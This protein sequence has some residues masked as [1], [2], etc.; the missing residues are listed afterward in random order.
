MLQRKVTSQLERWKRSSN[1]ALLVY[2]ARQV[3]KTTAIRDFCSSAFHKTAEINFS[4]DAH[5]TSLFLEVK[6]LKDFEATLALLLGYDPQEGDV[7]FFDEIQV[8][9]EARQRAIAANPEFA[10]RSTDLL[11]LA[12]PIAEQGKYRLILS[13]SLLGV[14]V[15]GINLN[16]TG[17]VDEITMYPMDFEEFLWADKVPET[18]ISQAKS[19]FEQ[20]APMGEELNGFFLAEYRKYTVVGGLP[21]AVRRYVETKSLADAS[22]AQQSVLSWYRKDII[23]YAPAGSRLIILEMFQ[24]LP[25]E[26]NAKNKKFVKSHM[27]VPNFK[28]LDLKDRFLWLSSA[29]IALPVY[30][31]D[32]PVSPLRSSV[33]CKTVKLFSNDVGLLV[34]QLFEGELQDSLLLPSSGFDFGA[35]YENAAATQLLCHG[36]L[37]YYHSNK[38]GGEIDFLIE[39]DLQVLP[40]EIKSGK[41]NERGLYEHK[42]LDHY[43]ES[44]PGKIGYV[45]GNTNVF[46]ERPNIRNYPIYM[47]EFLSKSK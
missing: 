14:T 26:V 28:N 38:K 33:N 32:N 45:F 25:S 31:V 3:G 37:P 6:N 18:F 44:N 19:C 46:S 13:G 23:K 17:F 27:D 9:Y 4:F 34:N 42:A 1:N 10:N 20:F 24:I 7:V 5:A 30:N 8:Y 11:T 36:F 12:K 16:P 40:I 15:F 29:G 39:K 47:L 43:L 22:L 2:G 41:P 35:V 21:E